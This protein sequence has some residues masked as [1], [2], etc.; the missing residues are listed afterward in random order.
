MFVSSLLLPSVNNRPT[1][2]ALTCTPICHLM[3]KIKNMSK[4]RND[5]KGYK[6]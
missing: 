6:H 2:K 5:L 1:P 3:T 4:L